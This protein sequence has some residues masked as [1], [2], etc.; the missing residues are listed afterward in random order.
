MNPAIAEFISD[1]FYSSDKNIGGLVS[2]PETAK[3]VNSFKVF[4]EKNVVFLDVGDKF[5]EEPYKRSFRRRLEAE[6]HYGETC[7]YPFLGFMTNFL[8]G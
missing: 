5:L 6:C 3:N 7:F 8:Q 4:D 2:A 1:E